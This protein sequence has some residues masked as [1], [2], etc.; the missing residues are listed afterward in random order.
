MYYWDYPIVPRIVLA[1]SAKALCVSAPS[2]WNSLSFD[3]HVMS[4]TRL[5]SPA[6]P[7]EAF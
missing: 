1:L 2:V 3:C 7:D 4:L 5:N 6:H